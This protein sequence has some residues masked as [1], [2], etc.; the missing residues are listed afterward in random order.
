MTI[1]IQAIYTQTVG[2]SG[3]STIAFNNI[4]QSFTD[5]KVVVSS[6]TSHTSTQDGLGLYINGVQTSRSNTVLNG[7]GTAATSNRGTYRDVGTSDG[8]TATT[9]TFSNIEIYIPNYSG[10]TFKQFLSDSVMEN[11]TAAA[12]LGLYA[13]LWSSTAAITSLTFDCA[14]SGL[15]FLQY[16]TFTLYGITKG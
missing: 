5:L 14:T 10:S 12:A 13:N 7:T 4:P 15:N 6:R 3:V 2:A 11:N 16:S 1:A 9:N 8:N